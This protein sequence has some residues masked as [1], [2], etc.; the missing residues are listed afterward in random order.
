M[1]AEGENYDSTVFSRKDPNTI[2][3]VA[4]RSFTSTN[5]QGKP[6]KGTSVLER[7]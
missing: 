6:V 7:E 4:T 3:V 5:A 2:D 1:P